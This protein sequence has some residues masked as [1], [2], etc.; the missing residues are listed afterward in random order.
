MKKLYSFLLGFILLTSYSYAVEYDLFTA[1]EGNKFLQ[2]NYNL[3]G[4]EI[5]Q[6]MSNWYPGDSSIVFDFVNGESSYWFYTYRVAGNNNELKSWSFLLTKINGQFSPLDFGV[7]D[8]EFLVDYERLP[9]NWIDSDMLPMAVQANSNLAQFLM[10]NF[11]NVKE[12]NVLLT[13][14]YVTE[15]N[16][17]KGM[18]WLT[19]EINNVDETAYCIFNATTL[20]IVECFVPDVKSVNE[21]GSNTLY[22]YPNPANEYIEVQIPANTEFGSNNQIKVY[23][24][25]GECMIHERLKSLDSPQRINLNLLPEG[26]YYLK[27]GHFIKP[28]II[29]R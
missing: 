26:V 8:D 20:E 24:N 12:F 19:V 17:P 25:M 5:F 23:N 14:K 16:Y 2:E 9:Q 15:E 4:W 21:I 6:I 10:E 3:K 11:E 28:F 1:G 18:W 22:C 13:P 29:K 27:F 7:E